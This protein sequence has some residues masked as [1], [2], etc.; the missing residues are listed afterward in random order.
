LGSDFLI[1]SVSY[2]IEQV[3]IVDVATNAPPSIAAE[4]GRSLLSSVGASLAFDTRNNV[5]LPDRGQRTELFGELTGGPFGGDEDFY[6]LELKTAWYFKGLFSG[7]VMEIVGRVGVGDGLTGSKDIPFYDRYYLGGLYSLRGYEYREIGPRELLPGTT[8]VYEPVGGKT[9]WFATAEYSIPIIE[10]LRF[11]VF[12]DIGMVYPGAWSFSPDPSLDP[13]GGN[14]YDTG[15]YAD[16]W[17]IGLRLN[18]PIGP[19]RLDY[20]FP[21]TAPNGVDDDGQFQF[22]VGY[23]REF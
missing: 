10:R 15:S 6:K 8:G 5:T 19:L 7:H 18:L 22:G 17:G 3:G 23:T 16:N 9:Y 12:Y 13:S 11:A 21:I 20:G 4:E 2:N 14:G 1:G